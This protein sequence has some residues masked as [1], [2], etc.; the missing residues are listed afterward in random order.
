MSYPHSNQL[1]TLVSQITGGNVVIQEPIVGITMDTRKVLPGYCLLL[2]PGTQVDA[3]DYISPDTNATLVLYEA[4]N[5]TTAQQQT[6]AQCQSPCCPVQQL[7]SKISALAQ[8]FYGNPTRRCQVVA[9][10]GTN[11]KTSVTHYCAQAL[12]ALSQDAAV[13]GTLGVGRLSA[14]QDTGMTTPDAITAAQQCAD[15]VGSGATHL[16]IE[17]S[18][19]ALVQ[20]RM[21]AA[22]VNIGVFTNLSRDHL[23]YH[24]SWSAYKAAKATLWQQ[25]G[26]EV[27]IICWDDPVGQE[28]ILNWQ[29][30]IPVI[31]V[32]CDINSQPPVPAVVLT[33]VDGQQLSVRT[34]WGEGSYNTT[35][36]ADFNIMNSLLVLACLGWMGFDFTS[37]LRAMQSLTAVTGR[38]QCFG[39]DKTPL[40]IVDFAHTPDALQQVLMECRQKATGRVICVF[41]CGGD[42]DRGKRG[43]MGLIASQCAD[44]VI[45]TSDNPR[46]EDPQLISNEIMQAFVSGTSCECL[47][48]RSAAIKKAIQ[49]AAVGDVVLIAGKGHECYQQLDTVR[50][51]HSDQEVVSAAL[52][53]VE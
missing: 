6:I 21:A 29:Y 32:T 28:W 31:A 19:H 1:M 7:S 43:A 39:S 2:V 14:L 25:P 34:P 24:G 35:L 13:M 12:H 40:V 38:M 8:A 22:E 53:H 42:R 47:L 10:T 15:L 51:K 11:G 30:D 33:A 27:A 23:D 18:S 20:Q 50:V 46:S 16:A 36:I 44:H 3:R 17:M 5:I 41:G 52:Q 4:D 48:D 9:V 49:I 37:S 45:V 26:L